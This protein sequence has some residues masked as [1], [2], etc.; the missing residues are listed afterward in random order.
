M[1]QNNIYIYIMTNISIIGL[2]FVGSAMKKSFEEKG[3]DVIG[4]DKYKESDPHERDHIHRRE[5]L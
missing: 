4:Y 5:V 2:G 3:C 1:N